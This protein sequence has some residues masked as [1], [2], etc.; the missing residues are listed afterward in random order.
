MYEKATGAKP[1]LGMMATDSDQRELTYM[2]RGGCNTYNRNASSWP[3]ANWTERDV[4]EYLKK[5]N[6]PYS[7]IYDKGYARTGCMTCLFGIHLD[8]GFKA[9][10]RIQTL[11]RTHPKLWEFY[12]NKTDLPEVMTYLNLPID[13]F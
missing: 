5:Y 4:W 13:P 3:L 6:V 7:D 12:T 11:K 10:N 9:E 2:S 1:Y 8:C